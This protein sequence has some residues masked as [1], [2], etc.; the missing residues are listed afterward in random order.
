MISRRR[1]LQLTVS[2]AACA[3]APPIV[4]A[5]IE[6]SDVTIGP[7]RWI[8]TV[9][10][11]AEWLEYYKFTLWAAGL[12]F[13]QMI[14]ELGDDGDP[15]ALVQEFQ[16]AERDFLALDKERRAVAW[17]QDSGYVAGRSGKPRC[18]PLLLKPSHPGFGWFNYWAVG[19]Y[20]R[21]RKLGLP[22]LGRTLEE[23]YRIQG[24]QVAKLHA[25]HGALGHHLV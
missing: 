11:V 15:V 7:D 24:E 10:E 25:S 5:A 4:R 9:A 19:D 16:T 3:A 8:P 2:L 1:F 14:D 12:R 13:Q 6:P 20:D 21:R 23:E 22:R 18:N 17:Q